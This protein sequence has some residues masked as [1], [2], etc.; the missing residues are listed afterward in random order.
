MPDVVGNPA[1]PVVVLPAIP[2]PPLVEA[3]LAEGVVMVVAIVALVAVELPELLEPVVV[4]AI[5][6]PF[7]P[8]MSGGPLLPGMG[9]P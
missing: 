4:P 8:L 6:V 7:V 5:D 2:V 9:R 1:I 3:G